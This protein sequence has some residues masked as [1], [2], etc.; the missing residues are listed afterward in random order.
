MAG[1][2]F[3]HQQ[4]QEAGTYSVVLIEFEAAAPVDP[5]EVGGGQSDDVQFKGLFHKH[6]VVLRH[7]EAVEVTREQGGTKRDRTDLLNL[8]QRRLLVFFI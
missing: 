7:A 2:T 1:N 3:S 8:P 6:N 5:S 4:S